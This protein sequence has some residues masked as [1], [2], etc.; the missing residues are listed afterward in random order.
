MTWSYLKILFES[1]P[2]I[3]TNCYHCD[4]T[5]AACVRLPQ[6][7]VLCGVQNKFVS[8]VINKT[9]SI[10]IHLATRNLEICDRAS[11]KRLGNTHTRAISCVESSCHAGHAR[12]VRRTLHVSF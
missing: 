2:P 10:W 5:F 11:A 6:T 9:P 1:A 4:R 12:I 8:G 7:L 3:L